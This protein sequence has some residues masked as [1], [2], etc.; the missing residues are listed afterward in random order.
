M[1][2]LCKTDWYA[3]S[4]YAMRGTTQRK[5]NCWPLVICGTYSGAK[6]NLYL[7]D[8]INISL[9]LKFLLSSIIKTQVKYLL[10]CFINEIYKVKN[11]LYQWN[12]REWV[13]ASKIQL[14]LS[15]CRGAGDTCTALFPCAKIFALYTKDITKSNFSSVNVSNNGIFS[16]IVVILRVD[17][18]LLSISS[19]FICLLFRRR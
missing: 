19:R 11:K 10:A 14:E 3:V 9:W 4:I 13:L 15:G 1:K 17:G 12:I 2:C 7:L 5:A 16:L 8:W 6:Q 18:S